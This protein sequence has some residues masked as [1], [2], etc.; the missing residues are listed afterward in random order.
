MGTYSLD[1]LCIRYGIEMDDRH[2]AAGDAFLTAQLF[3][4]LLKLA[5]KK[6]IRN[7]KDLLR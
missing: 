2:T 5:E 7:F 4:K 3:L 1:E 6:G